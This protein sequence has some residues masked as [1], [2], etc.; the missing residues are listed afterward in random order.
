MQ[1]YKPINNNIVSAFDEDGMETILIGRGIGYKARTGDEIPELSVQKVFKMSSQRETDRLKELFASIPDAHLEVTDDIFSYA[2]DKLNKRLNERAFISLADHISFAVQRFRQGMDFQNLLLP[3]V[4]RLYAQE[5]AI[6]LHALDLMERRLGFR[7][8]DDEAASIAMHIFNAEY[9]V[10]IGDV[11][12]VTQ[13]LDR[14]LRHITQTMEYALDEGDYHS[15]RFIA[16][17]KFLAQR[18]VQ[19]QKLA[20]KDNKLLDFISLVAEQYPRELTCA[21]E[22]AVFL[23]EDYGYEMSL[24]E[25][26]SMAIH[27]KRLGS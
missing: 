13:L 25:T 2:R 7:F 12:H 14:V 4:R 16:H 23:R 1:V 24:E 9:D 27:I 8:P 20:V 11:F 17:L 5:Y 3:E 18:V 19:K 10:S 26:A 22:I 6:G 15:Q 21:R